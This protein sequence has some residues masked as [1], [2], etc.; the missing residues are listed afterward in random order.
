MFLARVK[1]LI[2]YIQVICEIFSALDEIP[3]PPILEEF[4]SFFQLLKIT[5]PQYLISPRC[6]FPKFNYPN[7]YIEFVVGLSFVAAVV[8]LPLCYYY[9]RKCLD[10]KSPE[11]GQDFLTK[12]K[13]RCFLF[14]VML[15]FLSYPS[16][17]GVIITLLPTGCKEFNIGENESEPKVERLR[18]D[19]SID[20][21]DERH[22][23]FTHAAETAI[24]YVVGF[25][26]VLLLLMW[27][28]KRITSS[29]SSTCHSGDQPLDDNVSETGSQ[30]SACNDDSGVPASHEDDAN[31]NDRD[32]ISWLSFM[33][34]NYKVEFWFWEIVELSRK[35]LQTLFILL[36]GPEDHFAL[37]ASIVISVGFLLLQSYWKPMKDAAEHRLQLCSLGTIF[38]NLLV[39]SFLLLPST[40]DT[41]EAR[42]AILAVVLVILNLSII[43]FIAGTLY[44][45][46]PI[47]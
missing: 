16:M 34:E 25:P 22:L 37:F 23:H 6:F 26:I 9:F 10:A 8:F 33:W 29:S 11:G 19:Y 41:S 7:I 17:C 44:Y 14:V 32:Q 46:G 21:T 27:C 13:Q 40:S 18:Y 36:F 1:I 24:I 31:T 3:W 28:S 35:I 30:D 39:A 38:L 42:K 12:T 45:Q 2:G 43:V 47:S 20:C 5:I 4:G 15:L